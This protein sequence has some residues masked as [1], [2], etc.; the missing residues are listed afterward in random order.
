MQLLYIRFQIADDKF[1]HFQ[2]YFFKIYFSYRVPAPTVSHLSFIGDVVGDAIA[3]SFVAFA[4]SYAMAK[5]L[6]ER[7]KE[8]VNANQVTILL[9]YCP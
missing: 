2:P 5:I 6:A 3:V 8:E 7:D 9:E 1:N 4:T